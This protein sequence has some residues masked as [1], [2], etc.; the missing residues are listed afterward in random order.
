[1]WNLFKTIIISILIIITIHFSFYYLK[2]I[3][4]P[5]KRKDIISYEIDKYKEIVENLVQ[6]KKSQNIELE[7]LEIED[8][9]SKNDDTESV[10]DFSNMENELNEYI[11]SGIL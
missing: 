8:I 4:T 1:M 11:S 5:K 9:L 7:E 6:K 10:V 2:D 3:L